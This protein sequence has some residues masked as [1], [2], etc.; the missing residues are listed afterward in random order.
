MYV[1][2]EATT[3]NN[4]ITRND[5]NLK[6]C[7]SV[8]LFHNSE[9]IAHSHLNKKNSLCNKFGVLSFALHYISF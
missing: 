9:C 4:G 2:V 1:L 5:A 7:G 8:I 6:I 3:S